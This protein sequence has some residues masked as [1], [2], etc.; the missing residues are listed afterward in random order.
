[1]DGGGGYP[2]DGTRVER[3]TEVLA[4]YGAAL[5]GR[6][7]GAGGAWTIAIAAAGTYV[8]VASVLA[9]RGERRTFLPLGLVLVLAAYGGVVASQGVWF[10]RQVYPA[11]ALG[12]VLVAVL[13]SR[14][15]EE[16]RRAPGGL[17]GALHG[18][19]LLVLTVLLLHDSQ[20]LFGPGEGRVRKAE[21]ATDFVADVSASI[22]G[23]ELPARVFLVA[24]TTIDTGFGRAVLRTGWNKT[25]NRRLEPRIRVPLRWLKLVEREREVQL[26]ELAWVVEPDR[27]APPRVETSPL[28]IELPVGATCYH[29]IDR[30]LV[31]APEDRRTVTASAIGTDGPPAY[32]WIYG[33]GGGTLTPAA[34]Q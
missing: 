26:E 31:E 30:R 32:V 33:D 6:L 1:M 20:G 5:P 13:T 34:E 14:A 9:A 7:D 24:P 25:G 21:V 29:V 15:L 8:V 2:T 12:A 3:A 16:T 10:P 22:D 18:A 19:G 11:A 28:R 27:Y 4:L 17:R 23:L